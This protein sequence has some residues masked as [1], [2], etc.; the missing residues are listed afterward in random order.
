MGLWG[1]LQVLNV[2]MLENNAQVSSSS[3]Q[4][5]KKMPRQESLFVNK[6]GWVGLSCAVGE[7]RWITKGKDKIVWVTF[8][9]RNNKLLFVVVCIESR[10]HRGNPAAEQFHYRKETFKSN[11]SSFL[12]VLVMPNPALATFIHFALQTL[13]GSL[14]SGLPV[15]WSQIHALLPGLWRQHAI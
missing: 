9:M 14:G 5:Y 7:V 11:K 1:F 3:T 8:Q 2:P 12:F 6:T 15:K 10:N 13:F 4:S